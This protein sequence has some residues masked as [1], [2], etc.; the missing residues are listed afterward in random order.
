MMAKLLEVNNLE[1]TFGGAPVL[2]DVTFDL[3]A[4]EIVG[5][6]GDSGSG[7]SVLSR[8]LLRLDDRACY[9]SESTLTYFSE[10]HELVEL[11]SA[12]REQLTHLRGNEISMIFQEPRA[13][14]NPVFTC[15]FQINEVITKHLGLKDKAV[16]TRCQELIADFGLPL[17][18]Y[19]AY[20][21]QVSGGEAQ[22]VMILIA[23]VS[24]PQ[25][26]IADEPTTSLDPT[27]ERIVVEH[28]KELNEKLGLTIFIVS[29][30][31]KLL[32][33]LVNRTLFLKDGRLVDEKE[34]NGSYEITR[35]TRS[36][37]ANDII[38]TVS[39]LSLN[40]IRDRKL[41][42]SILKNVSFDRCLKEKCWV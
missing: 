39:E 40:R 2:Q 23:T 26:L 12:K 11:L 42:R 27:N 25:L 20:P 19:D 36:K 35:K 4:G 18:I 16:K 32:S 22:R 21:F 29:H 24:N 8:A 13:A 6:V 31:R 38:L 17:R 5:L 7:K 14:L 41:P 30:D 34:I 28:L 3:F 1:I 33:K 37:D 10:V 15:G 9:G